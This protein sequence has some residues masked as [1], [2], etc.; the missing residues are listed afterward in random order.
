M[1]IDF[2]KSANKFRKQFH[3]YVNRAEKCETRFDFL[4]RQVKQVFSKYVGS[5]VAQKIGGS[6]SARN[7]IEAIG[8]SVEER[9]PTL[10]R[11]LDLAN[12]K[13]RQT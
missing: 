11:S 7:A 2:L 12:K 13:N 5:R 6:S 10:P 8:G 3:V 1:V 4:C 9:G